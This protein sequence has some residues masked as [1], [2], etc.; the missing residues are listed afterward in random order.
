MIK[1]SLLTTLLTIGTSQAWYFQNYKNL[2]NKIVN[3]SNSF[4]MPTTQIKYRPMNYRNYLP[5]YHSTNMAYPRN[6]V[7]TQ[8]QTCDVIETS[9]TKRGSVGTMG[10][11]NSGDYKCWEIKGASYGSSLRVKLTHLKVD[12]LNGNGCES[13]KINGKILCELQNE[14]DFNS[15]SGSFKIEWAPQSKSN[16]NFHLQWLF[17]DASVAQQAKRCES[18]AG[19]IKSYWNP[20]CNQCSRYPPTHISHNAVCMQGNGAKWQNGGYEGSHVS[21]YGMN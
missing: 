4:K 10:H 11:Q 14:N 7:Y 17:I 3:F 12:G 1:I 8:A 13:L 20:Y 2:N 16:P 19:K 5:F 21:S 18:T 9:Q 15:N 6:P